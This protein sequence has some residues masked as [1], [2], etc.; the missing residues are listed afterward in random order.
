M[1]RGRLQDSPGRQLG[2]TTFGED[3]KDKVKMKSHFWDDRCHQHNL[4]ARN[5]LHIIVRPAEL[6]GSPSLQP[7]H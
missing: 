5:S 2:I 4:N 3:T 1:Q 6:A 7:G